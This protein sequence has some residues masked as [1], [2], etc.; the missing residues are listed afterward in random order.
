MGT[1]W[2]SAK[3]VQCLALHRKGERTAKS[4]GAH[5]RSRCRELQCASFFWVLGRRSGLGC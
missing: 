4:T 2:D 3:R 5:A 1:G